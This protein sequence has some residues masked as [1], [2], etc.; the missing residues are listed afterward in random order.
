M[1][2]TTSLSA[3]EIEPGQT[4]VLGASTM[5]VERVERIDDTQ[6]N[7]VLRGAFAVAVSPTGR[8]HVLYPETKTEVTT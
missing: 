6:T 5:L 1:T 8:A 4:L 7:D 3:W 2:C